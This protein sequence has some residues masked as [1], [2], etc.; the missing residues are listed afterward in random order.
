MARS[1]FHQ[2][3]DAAK[4]NLAKSSLE[5]N[6]GFSGRATQ[7]LRAAL[8]LIVYESYSSTVP[9]DSD[10]L[11][12]IFAGG[13]ALSAMYLMAK[14]EN[15][16]RIKGRYLNE[17]GTVKKR[18]PEQLRQILLR[19]W[20]VNR[21]GNNWKCNRINQSFTIFL[22]RN[23]TLL[24]KQLRIMNNKLQIAN[25]LDY[26]RNPAMHGELED[27]SSEARFLGLLIAMFYYG[28]SSK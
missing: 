13:T 24:G 3:W 23:K 1:N 12:H 22:Y 26:I 25:R 21:I 27:P 5:N 9:L 8:L 20:G 11:K 28:L 15:L 16:L 19:K 10:D 18:I 17:N 6:D 14:L 2:L 4:Y 7:P